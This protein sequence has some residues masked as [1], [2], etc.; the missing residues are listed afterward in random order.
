MSPLSPSKPNEPYTPLCIIAPLA[1][2][3]PFLHIKSC[4]PINPDI[5]TMV[6]RYSDPDA[7]AFQGVLP[8]YDLPI[9]P[10]FPLDHD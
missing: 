4:T 2:I 5:G 6:A 7:A 8:S 10:T 3:L 1:S 9:A